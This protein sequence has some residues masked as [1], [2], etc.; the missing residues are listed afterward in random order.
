MGVKPETGHLVVLASPVMCYFRFALMGNRSEKKESEAN[1]ISVCNVVRIG[2]AGVAAR[3][4]LLQLLA[5]APEGSKSHMTVEG[6]PPGY[7][8]WLV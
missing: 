1:Q 7:C 4:D 3:V 5:P 6:A 2:R 8:Y